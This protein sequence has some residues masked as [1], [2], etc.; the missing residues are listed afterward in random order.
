MSESIQAVAHLL[1]TPDN[2][3]RP[4]GD[5][6]DHERCAALHNAIYKHGWI[7]SGRDAE[8][9][10]RQ[11]RPYL[12]SHPSLAQ[13]DFLHPS[14]LAFLRA[15]RALPDN[16]EINL[17]YHLLG[18]TY[19]PG[20]RDYCF[21]DSD[22]SLLLY[23]T[24]WSYGNDGL[25]YDQNTHTAILH[26]NMTDDLTPEQLWQPL[27]CILTVWIEMVQRQKVVAIL[28]NVVKT[29]YEKTEGGEFR[30]IE[31]PP[32]DPATGAKRNGSAAEPWTIV[33]WASQDL[34]ECLELWIMIVKLIEEKMGLREAEQTETLLELST[35]DRARIPNGFAREFLSRAQH[36]RF[37]YV[38]PGLRTPSASEF[39]TQPFVDTNGDDGNE[40]EVPAILLFRGDAVVSARELSWLGF[41]AQRLEVECPTGLYLNGCDR[42]SQYP[43]EDGC[44]LVLPF[45]F[46]AAGWTD[47]MWAKKSDYSPANKCDD[48][49][50]A[51]VN[52]Y[53]DIHSV[54]LQGFLENVYTNVES[55]YW[56]V[57]EHGVAGGLDKYRAADTEQGWSKYY[58]Q[59]G[60]GGYW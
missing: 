53:N 30:R 37:Q 3:P 50:Q 6:M 35:L 27:E 24:A 34:E 56:V 47:A 21:P 10:L 39:A 36:P 59:L 19:E 12:E 54:Q 26:L 41:P 29:S 44:S 25:V 22:Q 16:H 31:G 18:L 28:A 48:L 7:A 38:A 55:G 11:S 45:G 20:G 43:Q 42:A 17:F 1:V 14:V 13:D 58:V 2:P 46:E 5:G 15:A 57:D 4:D 23:G 51:G 60:P 52:P 9:F 33:P 40:D 49:L 32:R 8:D